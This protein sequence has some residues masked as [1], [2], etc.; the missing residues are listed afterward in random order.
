MGRYFNPANEQAIRDAGGRKLVSTG[1]GFAELTAQLQPGETVAMLGDRGVFKFCAD[2]F[3][4]AEYKE[5]AQQERTLMGYSYWA[6]KK[7]LFH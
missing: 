2:L 1:S 7:H 3:S 5:F 4:E 6:I